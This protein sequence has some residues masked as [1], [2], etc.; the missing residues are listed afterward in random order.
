MNARALLRRCS[1][2]QAYQAV[3][4]GERPTKQEGDSEEALAAMLP[5]PDLPNRT[6]RIPSTIAPRP[7]TMAPKP[8]DRE[9]NPRSG[10]PMNR[11]VAANRSI[12]VPAS[13]FLVGISSLSHSL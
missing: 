8:H 2:Q 6:C 10:P 12:P 11:M 9:I 5:E 3:Y 13:G 7:N 4:H 1:G